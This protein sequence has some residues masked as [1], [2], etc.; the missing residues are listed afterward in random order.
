MENI[1]C[2]ALALARSHRLFLTLIHSPG[3]LFLPI[4]PNLVVRRHFLPVP[5]TSWMKMRNHFDDAFGRLYA[6]SDPAFQC[7]KGGLT[8]LLL[9]PASLRTQN[10]II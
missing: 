4:I 9:P 5:L 3:L 7:P 1:L 8:F 10:S 6:S 2:D